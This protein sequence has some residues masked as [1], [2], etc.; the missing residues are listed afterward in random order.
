M[1]TTFLLLVGL[2]T[3][4]NLAQAEICVTKRNGGANGY[5][6]IASVELSGGDKSVDCSDPGQSP[7]PYAIE[8][9]ASQELNALFIAAYNNIANGHLSG[10]ATNGTQHV[11]WVAQDEYNNS[12]KGYEQ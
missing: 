1:K 2:I 3:L 10:R 9:G 7:C 8:V 5:K 11:T 12:I 6:N 4:H